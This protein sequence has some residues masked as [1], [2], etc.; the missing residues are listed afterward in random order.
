MKSEKEKYLSEIERDYPDI[1]PKTIIWGEDL[2]SFRIIVF[3]KRLREMKGY[4]RM[5]YQLCSCKLVYFN[6]NSL[7]YIRFS[8][9]SVHNI[10]GEIYIGVGPF[11]GVWKFLKES[12][13]HGIELHSEN[14]EMVKINSPKD[15]VDLSLLDRDGEKAVIKKDKIV[16]RSCKYTEEERQAL[17]KRQSLLD[18]HKNKF[19]YGENER[20]YHDRDCEEV[21]KISPL[22]FRGSTRPPEGYKRCKKCARR[23]D[24]RK[25]CEPHVKTMG[26]C[27]HLLHGVGLLDSELARYVNNE[28]LRFRVEKAGELKVLGKEDTWIIRGFEHDALELWHNNYVKTAPEER[29]ITGGFHNQGVDG[30]SI[31][32]MLKY[33]S[34]Y[35]FTGHLEWERIKEAAEQRELKRQQA[36]TIPVHVP[37]VETGEP[38]LLERKP[39]IIARIKTWLTGIFGRKGG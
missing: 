15:I 24:I 31:Q 5:R 38:V 29:Y 12:I 25:A 22:I 18:N 23:M 14:G 27:Y 11:L 9:V 39:G 34:D 16:Y 1:N 26:E 21:M 17:G 7:N 6:P 3:P 13:A 36:E 8:D 28:G 19:F 35:T 20:I 4:G 32:Y 33:I 30:K 2:V 10:T 37:A